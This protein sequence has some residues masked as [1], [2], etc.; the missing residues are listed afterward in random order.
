MRETAAAAAAPPEPMVDQAGGQ[1]GVGIVEENLLDDGFY[2][3]AG[4]DVAGA[5]D[6]DGRTL[7]AINDRHF[8]VFKRIKLIA[9]MPGDSA[10]FRTCASKTKTLGNVSSVQLGVLNQPIME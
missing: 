2:V 7:F 6:H 8:H 9:P 5:N 4:Y 10:G 3:A 1:N